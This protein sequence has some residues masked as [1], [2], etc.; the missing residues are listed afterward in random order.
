MQRLMKMLEESGIAPEA[1]AD[2]QAEAQAWLERPG[3]DDPALYDL[4]DLPFVTIDNEDS[5]DLDQALLVETSDDGYTVHYALA[6]AAYYVR[7]GSALWDDALQRGATYYLPGRA[8]P[9]LPRV[10]SE[11]LISLNADVDRRALV[12]RMELDED[13]NCTASAIFRGRIR[14]RAK[15]SYNG[16]KA[17]YDGDPTLDGQ[18]FTLSLQLLEVVGKLRLQLMRERDVVEYLRSEITIH[19]TGDSAPRRFLV[20]GGDRPEVERYNATISLLTNMEGA[21]MLTAIEGTAG[22]EPIYRVHPAPPEERLGRLASQVEGLCRVREL[23][24]E[25][26]HWRRGQEALATFLARLPKG[27]PKTQAINRQA[28][29]TNVASTFSGERGPHYGVGADAYARLS[30]PMRE[31]VGIYTHNELLEHLSGKT[32]RDPEVEAAVIEAANRSRKLQNALEKAANLEVLDD[33]FRADLESKTPPRPGTVMGLT[34]GRVHVA[35]DE[36]PIDVKVY[37]ED[38]R[39]VRFGGAAAGDLA[40]GDRVEVTVR[41]RDRKSGRWDLAL[42]QI[43]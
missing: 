42:S 37:L 22:A 19:L 25:V 33:L 3:L 23:D 36:P 14:S 10:L 5:R 11:G 28:V 41:S 32:R 1:P 21:A 24:P 16:V 34:G 20:I 30:S 29:M 26:W 12:M 27:D 39:K 35:L 31:V 15:L 2:V 8:V 43:R 40:L 17:L 9:M 18:D 7:P 6:D 4:T 13:G 38:A